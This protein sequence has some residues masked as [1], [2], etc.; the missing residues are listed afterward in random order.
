MRTRHGEAGIDF[1]SALEMRY[2]GGK[3]GGESNLHSQ[4]VGLEGFDRRGGGV[5]ERN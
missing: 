4:A 1:D 5:F 2:A 3:T